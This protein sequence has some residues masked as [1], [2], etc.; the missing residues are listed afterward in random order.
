M[1]LNAL[2]VIHVEEG[3]FCFSNSYHPISR[4]H[5]PKKVTRPDESVKSIKFLTLYL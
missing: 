3:S 1:R 4:S 5:G 2:R